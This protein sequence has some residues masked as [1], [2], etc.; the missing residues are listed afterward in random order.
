MTESKILT[1]VYTLGISETLSLL[2]LNAAPSGQHDNVSDI[3]GA[4]R[5]GADFFHCLKRELHGAGGGNRA[6]TPVG[7][8]R[9]ASLAAI[10]ARGRPFNIAS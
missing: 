1:S 6:L 7:T 2:T 10:H 3:S 8:D 4:T 5:V 9:E